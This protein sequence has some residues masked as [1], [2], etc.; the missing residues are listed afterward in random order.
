MQS[1]SRDVL[2]EEIQNDI[3]QSIREAVGGQ[4]GGGV[5]GGAA[6]QQ[7]IG[8]LQAQMEGVRQEITTLTAQLTPGQS[9]ARELAI[10]G[11]LERATDRLESLE[12]Q[13]DMAV[14]GRTSTGTASR[15]DPIP[16]IPPEA[17]EISIWFFGTAAVTIISLGIIR[18]WARWLDRRAHAAPP[19]P[20]VTPRFDRI[21]QAIEAVAIE[22]ERISEGQRYTSKIMH[23]ARAL[24]APD[25]PDRW[26][27]AAEREP[28]PARRPG[29]E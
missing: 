22:V 29:E 15:P 10:E 4:G 24:P 14:T 5:V 8:M 20:D 17:K 3:R 1:Q 18:P 27:V 25:L 26:P 9:R 16:V 11:Q 12:E 21:E 7:A 6:R 19:G 28:V 23:D 13:L 2:R